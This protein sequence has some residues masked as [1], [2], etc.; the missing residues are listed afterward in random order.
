MCP[1]SAS[2][3]DPILLLCLDPQGEP[4]IFHTVKAVGRVEDVAKIVLVVDDVEKVARLASTCP[5]F[6]K[7]KVV[8]C[9]GDVTRHR[10]IKAGIDVIS[11]GAPS[12]S[13]TRQIICATIVP[14]IDYLGNPEFKCFFQVKGTVGVSV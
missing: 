7:E 8:L 4:L 5:H 14:T 6:P 13:C 9:R 12:I 2:R 10:S 3:F 11:Q 1:K